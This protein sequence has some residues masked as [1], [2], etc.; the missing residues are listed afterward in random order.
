MREDVASW[1]EAILN[2]ERTVFLDLET[3]GLPDPENPP[4]IV[5]LSLCNVKGRPLLS[6][7]LNTEKPIPEAASNCHGLYDEDVENC[8]HFPEIA[9]ILTRYLN[10]KVVVTYNADFDWKVLMTIYKAYGLPKPSIVDV[11][12]AMDQYAIYAGQ[13]A[14]RKGDF[15]WQ[16]LPN[17]SGRMAHDSLVDCENLQKLV[18]KMAVP[19]GVERN[20]EED[21][22]NLNF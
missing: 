22:I 13:W 16:K 11:Q 14:P 8:P 3:T 18:E 12:C 1:A 21:D 20:I 15:K 6:A 5:Q 19:P 7:M 4:E 17:L 2:D 9:E 10:G